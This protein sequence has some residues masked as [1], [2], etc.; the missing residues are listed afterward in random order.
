M[1]GRALLASFFVIFDNKDCTVYDGI[2]TVKCVFNART[3]HFIDQYSA[4]NGRTKLGKPVSW[5]ELPGY[6]SRIKL[7]IAFSV[8]IMHR[9]RT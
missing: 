5:C 6:G 3:T 2:N 8:S 1:Q 9:R 7:R 4:K